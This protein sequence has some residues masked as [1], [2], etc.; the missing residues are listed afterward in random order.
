[1]NIRDVYQKAYCGDDYMSS[2]EIRE[3]L[4]VY[5]VVARDLFT[6]GPCFNIAAKEANRVYLWLDSVAR[7]RGII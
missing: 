6:L 1:M 2:N 3:A 5:E 4:K 7:A